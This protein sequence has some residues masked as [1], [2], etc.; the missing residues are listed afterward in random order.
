MLRKVFALQLRRI[1]QDCYLQPVPI[2]EL[3]ISDVGYLFA[4]HGIGFAVFRSQ[5]TL[6]R[7]P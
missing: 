5:C 3:Y 6:T 1:V 7:R 2:S 4:G